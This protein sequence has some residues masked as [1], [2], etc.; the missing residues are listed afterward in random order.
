[1]LLLLLL[2]L[3]LSSYP[4]D[5]PSSRVLPYVARIRPGSLQLAGRDLRSATSTSCLM[6]HPFPSYLLGFSSPLLEI[7]TLHYLGRSPKLG[8]ETEKPE[9]GLEY[10]V[11]I[12]LALLLQPLEPA[13]KA[14]LFIIPLPVA[15]LLLLLSAWRQ[16]GP[17]RRLYVVVM[18]LA[19]PSWLGFR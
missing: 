4:A 18:R 8:T 11:A 19:N 3:P 1:M 13:W 14:R 17:H 15:N 10:H 7:H 5:L 6:P 9:P 12:A 16:L 2:L